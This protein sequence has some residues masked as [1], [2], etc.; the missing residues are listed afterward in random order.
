MLSVLKFDMDI[1][2]L[3]IWLLCML[4]MSLCMVSDW[5]CVY[6]LLMIVVW[7][8]LMICLIEFSLIRW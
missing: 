4:Y 7:Y 8:M 2:R 5:L 1:L 6:V 3:C